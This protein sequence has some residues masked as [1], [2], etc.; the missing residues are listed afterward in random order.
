MLV[1]I[2]IIVVLVGLI[3]PSFSTAQKK[4][5]DARRQ[6]DLKAIQSGLEQYY[7]ICGYKYPTIP[8]NGASS[9]ICTSPSIAIMEDV[10]E[11]P[12][13]ATPYP[14]NSCTTSGYT[15]CAQLESTTPTIC[16]K[17]KQ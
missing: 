4:T 13:T 12:K 10:P 11:D 9:I 8:A 6:S 3:L 14:C 15:V 17:N 1:V 2:G 7:T 5:R 16:V